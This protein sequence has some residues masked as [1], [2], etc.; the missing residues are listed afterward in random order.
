MGLGNRCTAALIIAGVAGWH[1]FKKDLGNPQSKVAK[2]ILTDQLKKMIYDASDGLYHIEYSAFNL[3][4]NAGK[5]II[6]NFKLIPD[7]NVYKQ[8]LA[9]HKA[10]DN[11][12]HVSTDSLL[13]NNFGFTKTNDGRR[14]NIAALI[15]RR[16][17]IRL[18][19]KH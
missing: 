8:L 7:S 12:F 11:V 18:V 19:T 10:P 2:P 17:I 15:M 6:T 14:F 4:I 5:G 16:P 9:A 3:D 13:I 1:F